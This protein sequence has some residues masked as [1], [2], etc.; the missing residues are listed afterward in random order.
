MNILVHF[1][2]LTLIASLFSL[3]GESGF[4]CKVR[5]NL[6]TL[7]TNTPLFCLVQQ[8]FDWVRDTTSC[9]I[10]SICCRSSGS[11]YPRYSHNLPQKSA[12]S[13][14]HII[15][16]LLGTL[17]RKFPIFRCR[18]SLVDQLFMDVSTL[19]RLRNCV[20]GWLPA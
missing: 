13:R 12:V 20:D 9:S 4:D 17:L 14:L 10:V 6:S 16:C 1:F 5:L 15:H 18:N 7:L 11:A 2:F 19:I 8:H 3:W